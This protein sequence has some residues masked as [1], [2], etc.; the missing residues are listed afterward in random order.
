MS[1][2]LASF[3][4]RALIV[5]GWVL[6]GLGVV[7]AAVSLTLEMPWGSL[8]GQAVVERFFV[9]AF[10]VVS[11]ILAGAPFIVLGQVLLVFLNQ[12]LLV[13]RIDRRLRRWEAR[14]LASPSPS[15][16]AERRGAPGS[17][18]SPPWRP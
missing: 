5:V 13:A 2:L 14:W 16:A 12:R 7:L 18:P 3:W 11:G 8:T 4:A 15:A 1:F 9:A 17:A 6:V 10:L